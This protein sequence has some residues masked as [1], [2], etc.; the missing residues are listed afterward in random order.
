M[1]ICF[2]NRTPEQR[3]ADKAK[4]IRE[5]EFLIVRNEM[6]EPI[7]PNPDN[8][9][10]GECQRLARRVEDLESKLKKVRK[11]LMQLADDMELD[12]DARA[13]SSDIED[14]VYIIDKKDT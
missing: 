5:H 2:D 1:C 13:Y 14:I 11:E 9:F 12:W 8:P 6:T 10:I 7:N 3:A 4:W